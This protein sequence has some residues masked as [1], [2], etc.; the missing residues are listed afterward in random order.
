MAEKEKPKRFY[1][2]GKKVS[3]KVYNNRLRLQKEVSNL[4]KVSVR[5]K[6]NLKNSTDQRKYL[7]ISGRRIVNIKN[8]FE[9]LICLRCKSDMTLLNCIL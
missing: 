6:A 4:K 8:L 2:R 5:S 3:E 9:Q 1:C 7:E